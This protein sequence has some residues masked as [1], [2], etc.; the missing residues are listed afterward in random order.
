MNNR[1][2]SSLVLIVFVLFSAACSR[3]DSIWAKRDKNTRDLYADDVA[4]SIG[5]VLT[6]KINEDSAIE[7]LVERDLEKITER[8]TKFNGQLGIDHILPSIPGLTMSAESSNTLEGSAEYTDE[9]SFIDSI[10][11]VVVDILPNNNLV[12]MGT[13]NRN[14]AGEVQTIEV[15]GIVRISDIAFDN[16]VASERVADFRI[17]VKSKGVPDIYNKQGWL[18]SIFDILWPF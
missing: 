7:N 6:I 4:R 13:R 11:V 10:T 9:R 17:I 2:V 8:S 3:A 1:I 12:V 18:G 14:I 16:T 15:S 5:D